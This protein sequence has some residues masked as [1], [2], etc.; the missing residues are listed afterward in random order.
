[1]TEDEEVN[2]EMAPEMQLQMEV[3]NYKSFKEEPEHA[4]VEVQRYLDKGFC[5]ELSE[6]QLQQHFPTG[7][8]SKLAS[9]GRQRERGRV[10]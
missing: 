10:E 1:M 8:V 6:S 3:E 2:S 5:A 4:Q 7:T 9:F